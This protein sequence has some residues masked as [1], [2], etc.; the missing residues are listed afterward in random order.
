MIRRF[1]DAL[2][3]Q[4]PAEK[5]SNIFL[6]VPA[7]A[8]EGGVIEG[9][10]IYLTKL[11]LKGYIAELLN[12]IFDHITVVD[13]VKLAHGDWTPMQNIQQDLLDW[14]KKYTDVTRLDQIFS[15]AQKLTD[16]LRLFLKEELFPNV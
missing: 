12:I 9:L 6:S 4:A 14:L 2:T 11:P 16:Q 3:D 7:R 15:F 13:F 5:V 8:A 10:F 1:N